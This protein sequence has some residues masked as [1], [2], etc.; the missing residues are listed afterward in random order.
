MLCVLL[1]RRQVRA[2]RL[3]FYDTDAKLI[4][5]VPNIGTGSKLKVKFKVLPFKWN[6]A[7]GGKR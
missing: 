7:T 2:Y 5:D 3:R 1:E 4:R 6:A